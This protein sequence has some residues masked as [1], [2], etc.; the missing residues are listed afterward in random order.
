M[1]RPARSN[2]GRVVVLASRLTLTAFVVLLG[3]TACTPRSGAQADAPDASVRFQSQIV[4]K[5]ATWNNLWGSWPLTRYSHAAVYDTDRNLMVVYAGQAN[6]NG[7]YYGDIWEW[8]GMRGTFTQK[9]AIGANVGERSE[10]AMAYDPIAKKTFLFGG[11]Q[12]AASFFIPGQWEWNGLTS[13]WAARQIAGAE[14]APRYGHAMVWD[15]DRKKVLMFGGIDETATRRNDVWEW[16]SAAGTWTERTITGGRPTGRYGFSMAYDIARKRL[17]VRGGNTGTGNGTWV[18]ETWELDTTNAT[19]QQFTTTG[20]APTYYAYEGYERIAYDPST[21][22]MVL[23]SGP[24]DHVYEWD[25][26][27]PTW[28]MKTPTRVNTTET[29]A[30]YYNSFLYD[31]VRAKLVS[32]AGYYGGPRELW[33]LNTVDYTWENRSTPVSG[34]LQRQYPAIAYDTMRGKL[35]LFGGRSSV[36]NLYKQDIFE[37]SGTG[38]TFLN[39]TT[40]DTKPAP[41]YQSAMVYDSMRDRLLLYGGYGTSAYDDLWSWSP[42]TAVWTQITIPA[43]TRPAAQYGHRMFYDAKRDRVILIDSF[44]IWELNPATIQWTNRTPSP[45]PTIISG[46]SYYDLSWDSDR[47]KVILCGGSYMGL[48]TTDIVEWDTVTGLWEG[49]TPA[50]GTMAPVGR[51][52]HATTYDAGR[53][54]V[55]LMGGHGYVTGLNEQLNDSWEWSPTT[56]SWTETTPP[57][58]KPL[59]RENHGL[60]YDAMR[61]AT[62]LY[63]GS[64]PGDTTYGPSEIWEYIPNSAPRPNGAGCSAATAGGCMSGNCVDGVC[65]AQ[66]AA[67][68]NGMCRA[69]NVAGSVGTCANVPAGLG[70]DT[71]T[72]D[73]ACNAAQQCKAKNGFQCQSYMDC[74]SGQCADGV[75]CNTACADVCKVCNLNATKGTCSPVPTGN[76]DPG[77]CMSDPLQS[78]FCDAASVCTNAPKPVGKPCTASG[79]CQSGFCIDGVCCSTA[80]NQTCYSCGQPTFE[81]TCRAIPAGL[82]DRSAT[83]LCDAA[84]QYCTGSGTCGTNKKPNGGTCA[85]ATEC[86]SNFCVDGTCCN[87]TCLG[88]CQACNVAGKLGSCVNVAA[89]SQDTMATTTCGGVQY[90]DAAGTCQ[91]GLKPNGAT[92][93]SMAECGSGKCVDGVCC[94]ATCSDGCWSCNLPSL[95]GTCSR[96]MTGGTDGTACA[97]PNYCTAQSMCT[98]GKKPNGAT[99]ATD[100]ECGSNYCVDKTCCETACGGTCQT[101]ANATGTCNLVAA[102]MDPRMNCKGSHA[103]CAGTCD[104]Q[105]ACAWAPQGKA[106]SQAGCQPDVGLITDARSCD[107]AGNCPTP[108]NPTKNCNGFGCY[109]DTAGMAQCKTD[110]STDPE[111]AVRRY[112]EVVADGGIAD[113]GVTSTCPAAFDIGHACTRNAQCINNTCS[114]GVCCNINCDK[115]GSCNT[116]GSIGTCIPIPAG[117][118]PDKDCQDSMSDPGGQCGGKCDGHAKCSYPAVGTSCGTAAQP[119]K[120][121][122]GVGLCNLMP[123]DDV[124]CGTIDCDTLDRTCLDYNDLTTKRCG[125]LGSCKAPNVAASCTDI[126]QTCTPDGGVGGA[127]GRGGSTGG[128][129]SGGRGGTTGGGGNTSVDGGMTGGGGGG[130]GCEVAGFGS[131]DIGLMS[132]LFGFAGLFAMRRRR[133]R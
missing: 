97:A 3:A 35:M 31:P 94:D 127:G 96:I 47:G 64:V 79:Q 72:S 121:C 7:P 117:T 78:R 14:P 34:P 29:P 15:P 6:T 130:C 32:F 105:G 18:N 77:T 36:D 66:T 11:W 20:T 37:W 95:A 122:N 57:G 45:Q 60:V 103:T 30:Y 83:T 87:S 90:C 112:C 126:T 58:V 98:T 68:C 53:R 109:T 22:K 54:V 2:G 123:E 23:Q 24:W 16:D 118:D 39:R 61:G 91:S 129:G 107:G 115:C 75:C 128:G 88:T 132:L 106:C 21:S 119:C 48:Y 124:A 116:P 1:T 93:G 131:N 56:S 25:P 65:C 110:C 84:N 9:T 102:G 120:S 71:C 59:P 92:C 111:C 133:R 17:M 125:A 13:T 46:R 89:G 43:G 38:A 104:G 4:D 86:G 33:E 10:H 52:Y 114:D 19:W 99:C 76:E 8:N 41:R 82:P 70:D 74:A 12:P 44:Q 55:V 81:G 101:C 27:T 62:F 51:Y 5:P 28:V 100:N 80:C 26:V 63:G 49:K 67:A 69:C 108:L 40:V 42:T 50:G 113:G 85:A 73:Q